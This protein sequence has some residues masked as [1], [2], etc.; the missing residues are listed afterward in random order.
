[1][2]VSPVSSGRRLRT[3]SSVGVLKVKLHFGIF[4]LTSIFLLLRRLQKGPWNGPKSLI[5]DTFLEAQGGVANGQNQ[6]GC[7][8]LKPLVL[9]IQRFQ[10]YLFRR[11]DGSKSTVIVEPAI[12]KSRLARDFFRQ[13]GPRS[14]TAHI[15]IENSHW[16]NVK[17][18]FLSVYV[19][20]DGR[21]RPPG[22]GEGEG[23]SLLIA[24]YC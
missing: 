5:W 1:M 11:A 14:G 10:K 17:T 15:E 24:V 13:C 12:V 2:S 9:S 20:S 21:G 22:G 3:L 8:A 6:G 4:L 18:V 16:S 7:V 23:F 19:A